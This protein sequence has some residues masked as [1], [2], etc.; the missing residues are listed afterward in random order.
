MLKRRNAENK[1]TVLVIAVT[2]SMI[3]KAYDLKHEWSR[4]KTSP[5]AGGGRKK[6]FSRHLSKVQS[7][8]PAAPRKAGVRPLQPRC[9]G[10]S[11]GILP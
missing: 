11:L 3:Y 8:R 2:A 5:G 10:H 6:V 4:D 9:V 1:G 7:P